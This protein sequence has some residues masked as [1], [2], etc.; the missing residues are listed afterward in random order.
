MSNHK[1][2][3]TRRLKLAGKRLIAAPFAYW[4]T[5]WWHKLVCSL[6]V[7]LVLCSCGMYSIA[8]WYQHTQRARPLSLGVTFIP[9]YAAYLGLDAHQTYTAILDDLHVKH[10]RLVS[11]WSDIEPT[12]G[13]YDFAELDY[14]MQ[15]A[16]A[17]GAKVSLAIGLRQPRW[18][19]C[20]PPTWADTTQPATTWQPQLERYMS[21]VVNRYKDS[22]AL[23]SY[24]LENEYYLNAFGE[25]H[26]FDRRRLASELALVQWLDPSRPVIMSRSNNYAGF[27]L[28]QP[29][30]DSIGISIYRHVWSA[31]IHRYFTYPFPSWYYAFLAGAEQI[32][33]GKP[34][35]IHELQAEPWPPN[36]QDMLATSLSEQ[37]KTFDAATLAGTVQFGKQTGIRQ[38]D[39]WGAE[40][41]YYRTQVLHDKSVWN[42]AKTVF[43]SP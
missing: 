29:L 2:L 5:S 24:Q 21:A 43:R 22:P 25:C 10:L 7:L 32:L 3:Y 28:R 37:N 9:G 40:Y 27:S 19:E 13:S 4:Q 38:I 34:S 31:P 30:P 36:G 23:E 16:A 41:W 39:L 12:A 6:A 1:Q 20:H 17:H 14:E 8:R 35:L 33:T 26:N 11:Y 15:Q 42:T 18:P